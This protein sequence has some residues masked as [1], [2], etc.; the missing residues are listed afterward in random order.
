MHN[1]A[2]V[3]FA[4][5]ALLWAALGTLLSE[6]NVVPVTLPVPG[7]GATVKSPFFLWNA[8]TFRLSLTIP[9]SGGKEGSSSVLW[10]SRP[11]FFATITH[12]NEMASDLSVNSF[13]SDGIYVFGN[14]ASF[15]SE[16]TF[17]IASGSQVITLRHC[18]G[19]PT[20]STF[21]R[22]VRT[23]E[24]SGRAVLTSIVQLVASASLIVGF[25]LFVLS[26]VVMR[27]VKV[28]SLH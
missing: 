17:P 14:Q 25:V 26:L 15:V 13:R 18:D 11:C 12:D 20:E 4:L 7:G 21:V 1:F 10:G 3:S 28:A 8:G 19:L 9:M 27:N 16:A 2:M 5:S 24:S 6:S 23:G 22:L